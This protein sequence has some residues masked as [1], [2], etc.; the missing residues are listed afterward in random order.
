MKR[1]SCTNKE[2]WP[3]ARCH[4]HSRLEGARKNLEKPAITASVPDE[5]RTAHRS[6]TSAQRYCYTNLLR[7]RDN[8]DRPHPSSAELQT[9][10]SVA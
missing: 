1:K 2:K 4:P 10:R 5:N 7:S 9:P 3:N 8:S 6:N